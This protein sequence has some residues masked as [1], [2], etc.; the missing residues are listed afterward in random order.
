MTLFVVFTVIAT[1][2]KTKGKFSIEG[3]SLL[4]TAAGLAPSAVQA[5]FSVNEGE[6]KAEIV[7]IN[8]DSAVGDKPQEKCAPE[9]KTPSQ[10][11][12]L[13]WAALIVYLGVTVPILL[14]VIIMVALPQ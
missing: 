6:K 7:G 8:L 13:R 10:D 5:L 14:A 12:P 2:R 9:R 1:S 4:I 11:S 3:R